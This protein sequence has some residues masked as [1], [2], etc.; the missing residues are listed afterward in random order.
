VDPEFVALG[1][2]LA[3]VASRSAASAVAERIR[4]VKARKDDRETIRLLEEL[5]NDLVDDKAELTRIALAYQQEVAAKQLSP[6]DIQYIA[7]NLRP[8]LRQLGAVSSSGDVR[9]AEA[10]LDAIQPLLSEETLT[11][12]QL[13]GFN[14]REAI[15]EPMTALVR[16]LISNK[17]GSSATPSPVPGK[18]R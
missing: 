5:V 7:A 18:R 11:I 6:A 17:L 13:V 1:S 8:L 2:Q 9:A 4:V 12:V 10:M 14:V 16:D 3:E 15:G